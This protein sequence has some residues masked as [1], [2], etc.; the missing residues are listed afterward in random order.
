[1]RYAT[2][3]VATMALLPLGCGDDPTAPEVPMSFDVTV[4]WPYAVEIGLTGVD[5][6]VVDPADASLGASVLA[7]GAF[8]AAGVATLRFT[9]TCRPGD[10]LTYPQARLSGLR[11]NDNAWLAGP[12]TV[13][14]VLG[15]TEQARE[16]VVPDPGDPW[17]DYWD[18]R[19][20]LLYQGSCGLL[21]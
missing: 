12:C 5:W 17:A 10:A 4:R 20:T 16:L 1:M 18:D 9:A 21:P 3:L 6:S 2:L 7:D 13:S 11:T 15:C 8:D 14:L 19:T